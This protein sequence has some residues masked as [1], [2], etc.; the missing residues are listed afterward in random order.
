MEQIN[1]AR[2]KIREIENNLL[3]GN[4]TKVKQINIG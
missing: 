3:V 2:S 4:R 1:E